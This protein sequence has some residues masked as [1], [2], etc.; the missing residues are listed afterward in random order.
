[1]T[2]MRGQDTNLNSPMPGKSDQSCEGMQKSAVEEGQGTLHLLMVCPKEKPA[3]GGQ[4]AGKAVKENLAFPLCPPG[5]LPPVPS[6]HSK[7]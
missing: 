1:M 2:A 7:P 3:E 6:G 5:T 4:A